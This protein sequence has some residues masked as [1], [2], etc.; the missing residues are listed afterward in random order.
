MAHSGLR[1]PWLFD[2]DQ[3]RPAAA[4]Y[5][6]TMRIQIPQSL[7]LEHE[8]LHGFLAAARQETGEL[9]EA[10]RRVAR[11]LEPHFHKEEA[12]AMPPLGLLVRLARNEVT[13]A[14]AEVFPHTDWLKNNLPTLIAEHNALAVAVEKMLEAARAAQRV[15]YIEFAEQL[16]N[17]ARME[18][19][20]IYPAAILVGEY[21]RLRLASNE[22]VVS[23]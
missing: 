9:G 23:L 14:M 8:E 21:L 4:S 2:R 15:D 20:V 5:R 13:P 3:A 17:H 12:F 7:R 19:E 11:M 10:L 18:E 1:Q 22:D 16:I 6:R